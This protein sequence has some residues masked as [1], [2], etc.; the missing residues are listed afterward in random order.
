LTEVSLLFCFAIYA[1]D[2]NFRLMHN[3]LM[4][5]LCC[6]PARALKMLMEGG[7]LQVYM[8]C[9]HA[10]EGASGAPRT[11]FRA[12]K[13]QHFLGAYPQTPLT[14]SI[15]QGSTFCLCPGP[16]QSSWQPWL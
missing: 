7:N 13:S 2:A 1:A 10:Q 3:Y 16:C 14:P 11:H 6:L 4:W 5:L 8:Y 12:L 15:L 9:V